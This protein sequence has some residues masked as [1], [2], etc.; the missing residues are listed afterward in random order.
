MC[1][2]STFSLL[3]LSLGECENTNVHLKRGGEKSMFSADGRE[4][5]MSLTERERE[6]ENVP[7]E[8]NYFKAQ[9]KLEILEN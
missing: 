3:F 2:V 9:R 8:I 5:P 4:Q 7:S 1:L 6:K